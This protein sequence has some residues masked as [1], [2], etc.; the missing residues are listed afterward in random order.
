MSPTLKN[1]KEEAFEKFI[2]DELAKLHGYK[3]RD[4][5]EFYDR[6]L[7]LD[8]NLLFEFLEKTQ[9]K[10]VERLLELY[11]EKMHERLLKR[12]NEELKKRGIIDLFHK[13]IEEGPVKFDLI[14]F[15][16][17]SSLNK[18]AQELYQQNIWSAMRQVHF[19]RNTEQSLDLV[20]FINGL[21]IATVNHL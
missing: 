15:K 6:T 12:L 10:K 20:L 19:S 7:A 2:F 17:I 4:E 11:G 5:E 14:Y 13:G 3:K 18:E 9:P 21:P 16:P 1:L 8:I